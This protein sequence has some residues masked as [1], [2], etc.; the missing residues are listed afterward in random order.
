MNAL[1][2]RP[3]WEENV[4]EPRWSGSRRRTAHSDGKLESKSCGA[5]RMRDSAQ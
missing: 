1:L 2:E 3:Y 5:R 4:M